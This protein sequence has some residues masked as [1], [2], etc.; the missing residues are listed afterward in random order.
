MLIFLQQNDLESIGYQYICHVK[1]V[2][3]ITISKR[4]IFTV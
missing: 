4:S 3:K 2:S 1:A